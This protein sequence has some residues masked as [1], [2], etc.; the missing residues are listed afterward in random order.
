MMTDVMAA[1]A[2]F[3]LGVGRM[4]NFID[5]Q[6]LGSVTDVPWA[7]KFPDAD[8]FVSGLLKTDSG[9]IGHAC[10]STEIDRLIERGRSETDPTLRS[11]IYREIDDILMSEALVLPLFHEQMSCFARPEVDGFTVRRFRPFFPF[12]EMSVR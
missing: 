6:I 1:P 2:S 8:G 4:G 10:G 11:D 9:I 5:G 7:V 3:I 12:E